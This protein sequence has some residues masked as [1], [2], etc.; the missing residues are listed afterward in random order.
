MWAQPA[1]GGHGIP[2]ATLSVFVAALLGV[3]L[4][5]I[6]W[7]RL[8]RVVRADPGVGFRSLAWVVGAWT[9]PLLF[10]APFAS[11]DVW[12]YAAQGKLVA[13][14]YGAS[15]PAHVL[16]H[17]VWV[18]GV[19]PR[20]FRGGSVYGPGELDLSALFVKVSAG[21]PW[22]AVEC[23]RLAVIGGLLLCAWGVARVA[24]AHGGSPTEAVVAGVANPAILIFGVAGIHNDALMIALVAAG[25]GL[26]FSKRPWWG[27]GLVALAVTIKA[28]AALAVLALGWWCWNGAWS[29][30][31][32][33]VVAG[34]AL[35]LTALAV[36]GLGAGGGFGWLRSASG[37]S[38]PNSF[39]LSHL[40]GITASG[41]ANEIQMA[42]LVAGVVL[43][44][45]ARRLGGWLGAL[46]VAFAVVAISASN[47]QAWY[48]LWALPILACTT[49]DAK[50]RRAGIIVLCAMATLTIMPL[51]PLAW[52]V[53][54]VVMAV[55]W[56]RHEREWKHVGPMS[57]RAPVA[58]SKTS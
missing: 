43:V 21:H 35:T 58:I 4:L 53:G 49:G 5:W 12:L 17:S 27:L 7:L 56:I 45:F 48:L 23:W 2:S 47:T 18:S 16:S 40:A 19:D 31:A 55:M 57:R 26:A 30:R 24:A 50:V 38:L 54:I 33:A 28:P 1:N 9:A 44:L 13:S 51:G 20:Y 37:A 32:A 22:I 10:A 34:V 52:F 6:A 25:I 36:T 3:V 29:R 39:S 15:S 11:Q 14:G 46:A 42:G 41:P 8:W